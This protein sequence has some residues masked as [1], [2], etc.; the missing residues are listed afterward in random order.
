[1]IGLALYYALLTV[2]ASV[3]IYVLGVAVVV[4]IHHFSDRR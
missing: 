2:I 3:V 1:M 4:V